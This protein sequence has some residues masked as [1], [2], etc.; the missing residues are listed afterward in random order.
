LTAP[1]AGPHDCLSLFD[2][3]SVPLAANEIQG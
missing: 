3:I 2:Q 1:D